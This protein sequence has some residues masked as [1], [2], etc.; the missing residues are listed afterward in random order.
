MSARDCPAPK[1]SREVVA[2]LN[3]RDLMIPRPKTLP[4]T[5]KVAD[6]RELFGNAHVRSA[7][8][9]DGQ[10]YAGMIDRGVIPWTTRPTTRPPCRS[11]RASSPPSRRTIRSAWRSSGSMR[12]VRCGS[13]CSI[14][15]ARRCAGCCA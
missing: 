3:V 11:A 7:V 13:R 14:Q 6:V 4:T 5:A 2:G 9:V 1:R 8:L 12:P 15:T 10:A